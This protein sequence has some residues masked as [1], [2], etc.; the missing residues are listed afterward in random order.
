MRVRHIIMSGLV[1]TSG[2]AVLRF[3]ES[4][5]WRWP[6]YS[7]IGL[8]VAWILWYT[9]PQRKREFS[10]VSP[11]GREVARQ[12]GRLKKRHAARVDGIYLAYMKIPRDIRL[13]EGWAKLGYWKWLNE[14]FPERADEFVRETDFS[15]GELFFESVMEEL[16]EDRARP[17]WKRAWEKIRW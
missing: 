2:A 11:N 10:S 7:A 17:W 15:P 12:I 1:V 9:D 4:M 13:A 6:V 8:S 14:H 5:D 16:E 3:I